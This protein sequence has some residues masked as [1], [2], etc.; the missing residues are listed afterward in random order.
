[1]IDHDLPSSYHLVRFARAT[2]R[3]EAQAHCSTDHATDLMIEH[4]DR[5]G[6]SL[7][8]LALA[9]VQGRIRFDC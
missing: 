2:A 1:V 3:V 6:C 5:E 7:G 4:C 9:V 8:E